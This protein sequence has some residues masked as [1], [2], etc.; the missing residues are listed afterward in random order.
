MLFPVNAVFRHYPEAE[1]LATH[2]FL[3]GLPN[4][5]TL[6]DTILSA[7]S[8]AQR[9]GRL[10]AVAVIDLDGFKEIN[11]TFGHQEGD[12]FLKE[13]AHR[14]KS[15]SRSSDMVVRV[16]GDE[17]VLVIEQIRSVNDLT[18]LLH[19][20]LAALSQ[21][22]TCSGLPVAPSASCGVA[23]YPTDGTTAE[24]LQTAADAAMYRAKA[25][26]KNRITFASQEKAF[27]ESRLMR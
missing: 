8:R 26:G 3:T 12:K 15:A 18:V 4:R 5:V 11:D 13:I 23:V 21:P 7:A 22:M 1:R 17:F 24:Q 10:S 25:Q 16:G 20:L 19:R 14:L 6:E 27:P 9:S 2:D